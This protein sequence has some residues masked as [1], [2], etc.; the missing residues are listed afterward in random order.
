MNVTDLMVKPGNIF[1][2][3]EGTCSGGIDILLGCSNGIF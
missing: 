1:S 3:E 2:I